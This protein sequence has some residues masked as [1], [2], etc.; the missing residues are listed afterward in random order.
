MTPENDLRTVIQPGAPIRRRTRLRKYVLYGVPLLI[1]LA[2][3]AHWT[4]V[5]SGSNEWRLAKDEDGVQLWTLKTPGSGLLLV[6]AH[7]RIKSSLD[8]M[9]K[10]LEDLNSC[11]DAHCYDGAVIEH[12]PMVPGRYAAYVTFKFDITG[13]K[14]RQ[15]VLLQEHSQDPRTGAMTIHI[16]AAP[17]RLPPDPCCVRIAH[18]NN[19]WRLRPLPDGE[20]DIEFTQDTD[21]GGLPDVLANVALTAGTY[22][23]LR[24]MQDLMNMNKYRNARVDSLARPAVN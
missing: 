5:A 13:L 14:T 12:L 6:K 9:V 19:T 21:L 8:G 17:D 22:Q 18:L 23:I 7:T 10:L 16:L 4:W 2:V 1:A 20:L 11:V 15:Y 3:V 24:G